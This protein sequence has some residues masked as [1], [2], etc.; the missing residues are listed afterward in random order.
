MPT[1]IKL[2]EPTRFLQAP[3]SSEVGGGIKLKTWHWFRVRILKSGIPRAPPLYCRARQ[4][5]F[6]HPSIIQE[7]LNVAKGGVLSKL[8]T[9]WDGVSHRTENGD[10]LCTELWTY[11]LPPHLSNNWLLS[12]GPQTSVAHSGEKLKKLQRRGFLILTFEGL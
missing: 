6:L 4:P 8:E 2:A 7:N 12:T 10:H 3:G 11:N 1:R 5:L 9:F